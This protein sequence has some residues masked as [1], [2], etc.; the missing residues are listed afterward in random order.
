MKWR[1]LNTKYKKKVSEEKL[2]FYD[3]NIKKLGHTKPHQWYSTLKYMTNFDQLK[4]EEPSVENIKHLPDSVQADLI[5][6]KFA[7]V[8]HLFDALN[9]GDIQIPEF[10]KKDIPHVSHLKV[11]QCLRKIKTNKATVK[12]DVPAKV[13]KYLADELAEPLTLIIIQQSKMVSGQTYGKRPPL[14]QSQRNIQHLA[15]KSSEE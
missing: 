9:S 14:H 7:K 13:V 10:S 5:V 3:K 1:T 8:G 11:R 15:L 2:N 12:D 4:N 6:E